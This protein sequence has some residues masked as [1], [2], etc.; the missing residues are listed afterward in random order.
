M[1]IPDFIRKPLLD[2]LLRRVAHRR[3]PDFIIGGSED[4]EGSEGYSEIYLMRWWVIPRNRFFNIYFH[5]F[6]RSDEDRALHDHP[7]PSMSIILDGGYW[8]H[9]Q[10]RE[11]P[12]WREQGQISVRSGSALHRVELDPIGFGD[13]REAWTL[14][15]TGPKYRE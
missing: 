10:G 3:K 14:F 11:E 8:E 4:S 13:S 9:M 15:I 5:R 6:M 1:R 2:L 7:W 12:V